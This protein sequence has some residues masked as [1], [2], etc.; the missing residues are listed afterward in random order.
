MMMMIKKHKSKSQNKNKGNHKSETKVKQEYINNR[1][2]RCEQE[3]D[4]Y[5]NYINKYNI[6][7]NNN[8]VKENRECGILDIEY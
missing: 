8:R 1:V 6:E 3:V 4:E 2:Y 5:N 7:C